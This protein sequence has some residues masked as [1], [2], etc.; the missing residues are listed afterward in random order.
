MYTIGIWVSDQYSAGPIFESSHWANGKILTSLFT[1]DCSSVSALLANWR[2]TQNVPSS[3]C[4]RAKIAVAENSS[5]WT[6]RSIFGL[7][8]QK[9]LIAWASF[10]AG[11]HLTLPGFTLQP[12]T[13]NNMLYCGFHIRFLYLVNIQTVISLSHYKIRFAGS[14]Q[15]KAYNGSISTSVVV[16]WHLYEH[17]RYETLQD[18][19]SYSLGIWQ[20]RWGSYSRGCCLLTSPA[21]F[22]YRGTS[23]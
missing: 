21:Q 2:W 17:K 8:L 23:M 10:I 11:M 19:S 20:M 6:K 1:V 13:A 3:W 9:L 5:F 12:L 16:F 18:I 7:W 22:G 4:H 15:T 14:E